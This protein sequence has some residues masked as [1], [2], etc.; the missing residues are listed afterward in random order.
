[1]P[2]SV[3]LGALLIFAVVAALLM[4]ANRGRPGP[5]RA[6]LQAFAQQ[7]QGTF[8]RQVAGFGQ[9]VKLP[10]GGW[11]LTFTVSYSLDGPGTAIVSY[12]HLNAYGEYRPLRPFELE[13]LPKAVARRSWVLAARRPPVVTLG[14]PEL[15]SIYSVRTSDAAAAAA[16][17]GEPAVLARLTAA[18]R[19]SSSLYIGPLTAGLLQR[20][21]ADRG[22]VAFNEEEEPVTVERLLAI[23]DL[24]TALLDGLVQQQV[25]EDKS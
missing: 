3:I 23:R 25:A 21:I 6:A 4:A 17:L 22:A 10:A 15:D 12:Q 20:A 9:V 1:M 19:P 7:A 2:L 24:L 5:T 16:L 11:P 8:R 13:L 14:L 18:C